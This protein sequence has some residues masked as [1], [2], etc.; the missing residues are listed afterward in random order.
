M[1]NWQDPRAVRDPPD[2]KGGRVPFAEAIPSDMAPHLAFEKCSS[3]APDQATNRR[4]GIDHRIFMREFVKN[5]SNWR[6]RS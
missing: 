6:V 3:N 1:V 2:P 4:S 5:F